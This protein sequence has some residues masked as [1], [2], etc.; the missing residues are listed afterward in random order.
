MRYDPKMEEE[1]D[2]FVWQS[3]NGTIFHTQ[4][5]ISYHPVGRFEDCSLLF[6]HGNGIAAVFPAAI[7]L[8]EGKRVLRSH[9]G[10][11]YG[12]PVLP[13]EV[14]LN[15]V[16]NILDEL[17][18]FARE[19]KLDAIEI[20]LPPHI[21]HRC[22]CEELEFALA[23]KGFE[24]TGL[25]LCSAIDLSGGE[26]TWWQWFRGDTAR[27]IRRA[28]KED[29]VTVRDSQDWERYWEILESNLAS[30]HNTRPTHSL[31][32]IKRLKQLF[33]ERIRLFA[34]YLGDVMTGGIVIFICS[35]KAFVAFYIAQDY[36]YQQHRSLNLVLYRLMQLGYKQGYHYF[37]LGVSTEDSGK[38]INWGLF[39]FKEGFGARGIVRRHYRLEVR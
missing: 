13:F 18:G 31:E 17:I 24:V 2:E 12:G 29:S 16:S 35:D 30:R 10:A 5:F 11:T 23:Y 32:E 22:L 3:R 9:P 27:S 34:S 7:Q 6:R 39:R 38:V 4:R 25:E 26:E 28:E 8:R 20:R 36:N 37:D 19:N 15:L 33:P 14:D 1:W 21:F